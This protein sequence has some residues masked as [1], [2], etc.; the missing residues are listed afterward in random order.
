MPI[1]VK[2]IDAG[3]GVIYMGQGIVTGADLLGANKEIYSRD[4]AAEPYHYGL[5][6]ANG[7]TGLTATIDE[8]R[9]L[10]TAAVAASRRMPQFVVAIYAKDMVTFGLARMWETLVAQSGWVTNVF[11]ERREAVAWLKREVAERMGTRISLE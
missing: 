1:V 3:R 10:A 9:E 7:I 11:R 8:M 5:F 4:L 6:D 2:Y